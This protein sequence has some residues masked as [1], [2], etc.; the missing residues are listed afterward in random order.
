MIIVFALSYPVFFVPTHYQ[1]FYK[2]RFFFVFVYLFIFY[3]EMILL[4]IESV[5]SVIHHISGYKCLCIDGLLPGG[6][7]Q[8]IIGTCVHGLVSLFDF[9]I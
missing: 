5:S 3:F 8:R 7:D 1:C 9:I 4:L 2:N 6:S